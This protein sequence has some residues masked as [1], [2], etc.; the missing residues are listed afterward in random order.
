MDSWLKDLGLTLNNPSED[1]STGYLFGSILYRYHLQDNF[2]TFSSK[3]SYSE[4][5]LLKVQSTLASLGIKFSIPRV[6]KKDSEYIESLL[7]KIFT[8]LHNNQSKVLTNLSNLSNKHQSGVPARG[9]TASSKTRPVKSEHMSESLNRFE[10][11]RLQQ[12]EKALKEEKKQMEAIRQFYL[13]ER[14]KQIDVLKSN[15]M[16]LQQWDT[17]GKAN[18]KTNQMKRTS[19][20]NHERNVANKMTA[21]RTKRKV[22][23]NFQ[24]FE[25]VVDGINEFERNMIRLGVDHPPEQKEIKKKKLDIK[26]EAMITMAKIKDKQSINEQATK[27]REVRQM[28]LII[29]QKK[30]EKF[31]KYKKASARLARKLIT[32]LTDR[33]SFSY[34]LIKKHSSKVKVFRESLKNTE[35]ILKTSQG[36]WGKIEGERR[37]KLEIQEQEK[38][39]SLIDE[40]QKYSKT[41][42]QYRRDKLQERTEKCSLIMDLI[43][44]IAD[45]SFNY[46]QSS[47]KIPEQTWQGW[48]SLFKS[49]KP[50][51]FKAP[52]STSSS[53]ND[54]QEVIKLF[55][56]KS[57][58]PDPRL[59]SDYLDCSNIWS[60]KPCNNNYLL[61]DIIETIIPIAY[62]EDPEPALPEGPHYMPVKTLFIGPSFA[63][64]KTQLKKMQEIYGLKAFEV[65]KI[66]EDAKKVLERKAEAED[67]KKTKK[68]VE[69]E[70]EVFVN[71]ALD[72]Q[73]QDEFGRSRLIRAR[74]R[75][76]FGDVAKHEE[77]VKKG[78]KDEVKCMGFCLMNYP[79]TIQEATDL[80]RHLSNFVHPSELPEPL[81]VVKKR[82]ALV[83]ARPSAKPPAPKK[84]FRSAWDLVVVFDVDSHTCVTRAVD[85]RIDPAGNVYNMTY[86]PPPDNILP[87]C[88]VIEHPNASEV[89]E[90]YLYYAENKDSLIHWFSQFGFEYSTSLLVIKENLNIE[91]ASE[92]IKQRINQVVKMKSDEGLAHKQEEICVIK[93]EQA[94]ELAAEWENIRSG[95]L[96]G[97][98]Y[99]L[100]YI[101]VHLKEFEEYQSGVKREFFEFLIGKDEKIEIFL[102]TMNRVNS[103]ISA[104]GVFTSAEI[105]GL[106]LEIDEM[107]DHLWDVTIR[108]KDMALEKR[109]EIMGSLI[110]TQQKAGLMHLI[111]NL[112]QTEINKYYKVMNFVEKYYFFLG[113]KEFQIKSVPYLNID[114]RNWSLKDIG[115]P[116][117]TDLCS[118]AKSYS[119][120]LTEHS[121]ET[122]NFETR[123]ENILQFGKGRLAQYEKCLESLYGD[124]DI[125]VK[126]MVK[127]EN[128]MIN[129][130]VIH[131]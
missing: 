68:V 95:Y 1:F 24:H 70:A 119:L 20:V 99:Y 21:D 18:W 51:T 40:K 67:P 17:E 97:L 104:K 43:L 89:Q 23:D 74:L 8:A 101:D 19:R 45:T 64:K 87:K 34:T 124:L 106:E 60:Y 55:S 36:T 71:T 61:G 94:K 52:V 4:S 10:S 9:K 123:V 120:N 50:P 98:G 115:V 65:P 44:E 127:L 79:N 14:Q 108:R 76:A 15:K 121:P 125:W 11:V 59:V 75:S 96:D 129:K 117:L 86:Y 6:L 100:S 62:P 57:I 105:T 30:N 54:M 78:K 25:Q 118:K 103:C 16:F 113:A 102:R 111:C 81:A 112:L 126:K 131:K 77:E 37:E 56:S 49:S 38:K 5:N 109:K 2:G 128:D 93:I 58:N 73:G 80:E 41:F 7:F 63:G 66:I 22:E 72:T 33:Y 32:I 110:L 91:S 29:E 84:M 28:N 47:D 46:L 42:L 122:Y 85:R 92:A 88:K 27:E 90:Q 31:D 3:P 107:I 53:T 83:L 69:D 116:L 114:W 39:K 35:N 26:T 82:E 48:L 13:N 12:S 130:S